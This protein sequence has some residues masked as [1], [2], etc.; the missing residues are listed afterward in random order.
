MPGRGGGEG[1]RRQEKPGATGKTGKGGNIQKLRSLE[2][3]RLPSTR[4]LLGLLR[5][6]AEKMGSCV[7]SFTLRSCVLSLLCFAAALTLP[8]FLGDWS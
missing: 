4:T 7:Q 2:T 6:E 3:L 5:E 8:V 1:E